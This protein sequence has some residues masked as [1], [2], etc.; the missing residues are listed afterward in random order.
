MWDIW[1]CYL[2]SYCSY[3]YLNLSSCASV[4][5]R[6][7]AVLLW[8]RKLPGHVAMMI[9]HFS[10]NAFQHYAYMK[11]I[12]AFQISIS[13]KYAYI[14]DKYIS[15]PEAN[16]DNRA[17][18]LL[19]GPWCF[20]CGNSALDIDPLLVLSEEKHIMPVFASNCFPVLSLANIEKIFSQISV[21]GEDGFML[22]SLVANV[23][24]EILRKRW[25]GR[26]CQK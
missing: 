25:L 16:R 19:Q 17:T 2:W 20:L 9:L 7:I 14:N 3:S 12:Y 1:N 13:F 22:S 10:I 5:R 21:N 26:L 8:V 15:D 11:C 6:V 4:Q 18:E 24:S 23:F